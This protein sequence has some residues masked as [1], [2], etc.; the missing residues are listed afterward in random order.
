[1]LALF[2]HA[3]ELAWTDTRHKA[4]MVVSV[5]YM[6]RYMYLYSYSYILKE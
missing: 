1:M 6:Y 4:T 3:M 2:T 5:L